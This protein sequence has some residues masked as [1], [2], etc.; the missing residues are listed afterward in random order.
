M[1][2]GT[3]VILPTAISLLEFKTM[4]ISYSVRF[5]DFRALQRPFLLKAGDNAG[6]KGVLVV[7]ALI[8]LL[9]VFCTLEGLGI[10]VGGFLVG[11][12]FLAGGA[13][14]F[15]ELRSVAGKKQKYEQDLQA[16]FQRIHCRDQ[17]V[18][19]ADENGFTTSC[20]C[21]SV[22]RPWSELASFSENDTHFALATKMGAHVLPK[23]AF[24][25]AAEVTE[26]RA[27]VSGKLNQDKLAVSP[28]FDVVFQPEDYRRARLVHMLKGG[29]WRYTLRVW[30]TYAGILGG[31]VVLWNAIPGRND[32]LRAGLIGG[33]VVVPLI[34]ILKKR[35][36]DY[37]GKLRVYFG[38]E[39]LHAQY[40]STQTRRP[41]SQFIGY[42][43]D[44]KVLLLYVSPKFYTVV[45]RRGLTGPAEQFRA[46]VA[47]K[48]PV[49]DYRNPSP[50]M[51]VQPVR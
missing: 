23:S 47:S 7:C 17:R 48:L 21:E 16:T 28:H 4:R 43:E 1:V 24:A 38:P 10:A 45:P 44:D 12:G 20:K 30:L 36:A 26:F 50:A 37:F 19:A 11:L 18:F 35:R 15:F 8:A 46:L 2:A 49:Y 42:L 3:F 39:G 27:L 34:R 5:E 31:A 9:G 25:S 13:A 32:A 40:P 6:F 33:L 51:K 14:Y 41:W 22:T 29:G